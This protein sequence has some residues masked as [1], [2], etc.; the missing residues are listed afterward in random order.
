M[1][2]PLH[3]AVLERDIEYIRALLN[4][5]AERCD[6]RAADNATC[7]HLACKGRNGGD[8]VATE[9]VQMI[10]EHSSG[11]ASINWQCFPKHKKSEEA[12]TPAVCGY[13]PLLYAI[14]AENPAL[15]KLLLEYGASLDL[16]GWVPPSGNGSSN[17]GD[18]VIQKVCPPL[19]A[20]KQRSDIIGSP[21]AIAVFE[22][23]SKAAVSRAAAAS[24]PAAAAVSI[25]TSGVG[26]EGDS[27]KR[28]RVVAV[29]AST[30]IL[31]S[32]DDRSD[33]LN[34]P[35]EG[36]SEYMA[37]LSHIMGEDGNGSAKPSSPSTEAQETV[38]V[39]GSAG[40]ASVKSVQ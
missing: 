10:L 19:M 27:S 3:N 23:I 4:S 8:H 31:G 35:S 15:V 20:S 17:G 38:F 32:G 14:K 18:D 21:T 24:A 36:V 9:I 16:P 30:T 25:N 11:R 37:M 28:Q 5:G 6:T 40:K 7:L 12:Y 2:T 13:T 1:R 39:S 26:E 34:T 33:S 29:P 22:L